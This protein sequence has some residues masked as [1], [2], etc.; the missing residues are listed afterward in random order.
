MISYDHSVKQIIHYDLVIKLNIFLL[1][2]EISS[3]TVRKHFDL[4]NKVISMKMIYIYVY[5]YTY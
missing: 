4:M 1:H 5:I 3:S 2:H